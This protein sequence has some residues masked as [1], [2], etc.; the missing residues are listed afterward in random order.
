MTKRTPI[1]KGIFGEEPTR[2]NEY[3]RAHV[4]G[5]DGVTSI[6]ESHENL[7]DYGIHWLHVWRGEEEVARMN[8]RF[9]VAIDFQAAEGGAA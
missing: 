9:V 8:A 4:V 3:P 7:G 1:I 5:L 2:D 6:T